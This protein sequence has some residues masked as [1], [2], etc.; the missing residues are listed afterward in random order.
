MATTARVK[1]TLS[2]KRKELVAP[3][4]GNAF[5]PGEGDHSFGAVQPGPLKCVTA[6]RQGLNYGGTS[7][8]GEP[9]VADTLGAMQ[10]ALRY[11]DGE[12]PA[13]VQCGYKL[14]PDIKGGWIRPPIAG[15]WRSLETVGNSREIQQATPSSLDTVTSGKEAVK[16][17]QGADN[18]HASSSLLSYTEPLLSARCVAEAVSEYRIDDRFAVICL[19]VKHWAIQNDI[20]SAKCGSLSSYSIALLVLHFFQCGIEPAVLPNLQVRLSLHFSCI[21]WISSP[22]CYSSSC[23]RQNSVERHLWSS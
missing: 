3:I 12:R 8:A 14:T 17:S 11:S 13:G 22:R 15:T 10:P 6:E 2:Y 19:L 18:Q 21:L 20:G 16:R 23:I 4:A 7:V 1:D 5:C 9:A